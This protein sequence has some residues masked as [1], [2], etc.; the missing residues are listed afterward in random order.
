MSSRN[1][2]CNSFSTGIFFLISETNLSASLPILLET[3]I[4]F[5]PVDEL[6]SEAIRASSGVASSDLISNSFSPSALSWPNL[7]DVGFSADSTPS[8]VANEFIRCIPLLA[9]NLSKA[10]G[11]PSLSFLLGS[12][13][14]A[15]SFNSVF[16]LS[17]YVFLSKPAF[18]LTLTGIPL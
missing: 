5:L 6:S 2:S 17:K 11:L 14:L 3:V 16:A 1:F 12:N 13:S 7:F 4:P 10:I 8:L 18:S 15:I 9:I